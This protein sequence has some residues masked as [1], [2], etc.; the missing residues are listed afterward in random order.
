METIGKAAGD[1]VA[2]TSSWQRLVATIDKAGNDLATTSSWQR[3]VATV[4]KALNEFPKEVGNDLGI[5][6]SAGSWQRFGIKFSQLALGS[7]FPLRVLELQHKCGNTGTMA[8]FKPEA[9]VDG[10]HWHRVL[11]LLTEMTLQK[12]DK[13]VKAYA[14]RPA[15]MRDFASREH[16]ISDAASSCPAQLHKTSQFV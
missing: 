8:A 9:Y 1:N 6:W 10:A 14:A 11:R 4:D 12:L 3:L 2:T 15:Q 7:C 5:N 13:V 16:Q